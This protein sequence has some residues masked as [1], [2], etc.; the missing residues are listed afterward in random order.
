VLA[1]LVIAPAPMSLH[2]W[3]G[4]VAGIL[5]ATFAVSFVA[6]SGRSAWFAGVQLLVIYLAFAMTLYLSPPVVD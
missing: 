6:N 2:F 1:S 3:P 5:I 4:A